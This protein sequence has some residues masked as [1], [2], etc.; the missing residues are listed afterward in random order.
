MVVAAVDDTSLRKTGKKIKGAQ[1]LRDPLS[2]PFHVN[3][4]YGLRFVQMSMLFQHYTEG[5]FAPRGIPVRFQEA[6]PVKK[7]GKRATAEQVK[8]YKKLKKERKPA[9]PNSGND[10]S[11]PPEAGR[12]GRSRPTVA[13]GVGRQ[14]LQ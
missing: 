14:L 4:L 13:L 12:A 6:P 1:W 5:D 10:P 7:P 11:L 3:L 9:N 2:P 8:E